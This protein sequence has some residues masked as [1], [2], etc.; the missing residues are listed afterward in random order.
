MCRF[1]NGSRFKGNG[2]ETVMKHEKEINKVNAI[3]RNGFVLPS[4]IEQF[5]ADAKKKMV[6]SVLKV[7]EAGKAELKKFEDNSNAIWAAIPAEKK[8]TTDWT[9]RG[10]VH[11]ELKMWEWRTYERAK[12]VKTIPFYGRTDAEAVR[13]TEEDCDFK[14]L[15]FIIR[16]N[17]ITGDII[18]AANLYI[19]D[20]SGDV[21]GTISGTNGTANVRTIGAGGYNIQC[22]HFRCLIK[23]VK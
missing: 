8:I 2:K 11:R 17:A 21:N 6:E 4:E 12:I 22:Y 10:I 14:R 9:C 13:Y 20:E 18:T 23:K 19:D 7:R 16:T 15:Q 1:G 3:I 5:F